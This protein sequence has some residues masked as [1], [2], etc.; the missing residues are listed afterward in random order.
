LPSP[1]ERVVVDSSVLLGA[2]SPEIV[3]GAALRYY[4]AYWSPWI[5][6]EYVRIRIEWALMRSDRDAL[7]KAERRD[8][9]TRVRARVNGAIDYLS[10]VLVSVDYHEAPAADLSWLGDPDDHPIMMTAL[11]AKADVL[12]TDNITDFPSA[13]RRH[14]VLFLDGSRFLRLLYETVPESEARIREYLS[15]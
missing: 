8:Q 7:D 4:R 5:V 9:L 15:S 11:A 14:S 13:E 2:R 3:A 1:G 12:I 10:R 6:G